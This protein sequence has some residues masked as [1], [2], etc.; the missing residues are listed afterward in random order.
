[1]LLSGSSIARPTSSQRTALYPASAHGPPGNTVP[2]AWH[3]QRTNIA[4]QVNPHLQAVARQDQRA[5]RLTAHAQ[6]VNPHLRGAPGPT[7]SRLMAQAQQVL[8][9][10]G[11]AMLLDA[12]GLQAT[13][14][15]PTV[16]PLTRYCGACQ[17]QNGNA[18]RLAG[19]RAS[20][21]R[22]AGERTRLCIIWR[23]AVHSRAHHL[24]LSPMHQ[25]AT[26]PRVHIALDHSV[27]RKPS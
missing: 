26:D 8:G 22:H 20:G 25:H 16:L 24:P 15:A 11:P 23:R 1:M 19:L 2:L 17:S 13:H 12:R 14:R 4:Q 21:C 10:T 5:S 3:L 27:R 18:C 7:S 9:I 6:Q